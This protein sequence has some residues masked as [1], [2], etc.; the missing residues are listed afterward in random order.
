MKIEYLKYA[1][2]TA[3]CGSI[4]KAAAQL[5]ISQPH[6]S[7]SLKSLEDELGFTLFYRTN[8][9][10]QQT[11]EGESFL[12]IARRMLSDYER[13]SNIK[14]G[15][16]INHFHLCATYHTAVEEAFSLLC[17]EYHDK[18]NLSFSLT[19]MD[20]FRVIEHVFTNS[21][22]LGILMIPSSNP[23]PC[24]EAVK[25][26][27]LKTTHIGNFCYY[28]HLRKEHPLLKETDF[29]I[30]RLYEYPFIDYDDRI[31]SSSTDLVARGIINPSRCI[32]V[33]DRD[34]RYHIISLCDAF[35]IGCYPHRRI[36]GRFNWV[37]IPLPEFSF[38]M[39]IVSHQGQKL[40]TEAIRYIELLRQ[41]IEGLEVI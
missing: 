17:S 6:L 13:M 23:K 31:L 39:A 8:K 22:S 25:L 4:N 26:R 16:E 2:I 10:I 30:S 21:C 27:G 15:E 11:R 18:H 7:S 5:M 24:L 34:T 41:E 1:L 40:Q 3:G 28:I 29:D 12:P 9:G 38:E 37:C 20:S 32:L 36:R 33:D 35:S 19:N 14:A